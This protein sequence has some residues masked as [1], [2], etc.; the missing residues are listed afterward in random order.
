MDDECKL[1][2]RTVVS[3]CKIIGIEIDE[4]R[5]RVARNSVGSGS[6]QVSVA[7]NTIFS[8]VDE[9]SF[10][11]S[12][13]IACLLEDLAQYD[14]CISIVFPK[15][16]DWANDP[17]W[18]HDFDVHAWANE[19]REGVLD[20]IKDS[21]RTLVCSSLVDVANRLPWRDR[22]IMLTLVSP[23]AEKTQK[24]FLENGTFPG[25]NL[26]DLFLRKMDS[27]LEK[28]ADRRFVVAEVRSFLGKAHLDSTLELYCGIYKM[29]SVQAATS[30]VLRFVHDILFLS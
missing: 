25:K 11:R 7:V 17:T 4:T 5:S 9:I 26:F 23:I 6:I 21:I 13:I 10:V 16:L 30:D 2:A 22:D 29:R 18:K 14:V 12:S 8:S 15:S 19:Q 28:E 24:E 3:S 1:I 27:I 20:Y